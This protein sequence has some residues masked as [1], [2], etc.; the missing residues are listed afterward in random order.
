MKDGPF[1]LINVLDTKFDSIENSVIAVLQ[2][3]IKLNFQSISEMEEVDR[4]IEEWRQYLNRLPLGHWCNEII[5]CILTSDIDNTPYADH[6]KNL[7]LRAMCEKYLREANVDDKQN[8]LNQIENYIKNEHYGLKPE[9]NCLDIVSLPYGDINKDFLKQIYLSND[10]S[11]INIFFNQ[12]PKPR[13]SF[14]EKDQTPD[15]IKDR[16][17]LVDNYLS[18]FINSL[19]KIKFSRMES[20][21]IQA[22][23]LYR[24]KKRQEQ[25]LQ[26]IPKRHE[27]EFKAISPINYQ[28]MI[29]EAR[30]PYHPTKCSPEL[31]KRIVDASRNIKFFNKITHETRLEAIKSIFDDGLYGR[32]TLETMLMSFSPAALYPS[33]VANGDANVICFGADY[34]SI[35][36]RTNGNIKLILNFNKINFGRSRFDHCAFFKQMDFGFELQK[37]RIL[38]LGA[39]K[40]ILC[41]TGEIHD[42]AKPGIKYMHLANDYIFGVPSYQFISY[43]LEKIDQ[44]LILNFFKFLDSPDASGPNVQ[45]YVEELY[46]HIEHL[47]DHELSIF[48][49]SVGK[50]LSDTMEFNFFG[51]HKID[52]DSL[53]AIQ[54]R[55]GDFELNLRA[56]I[57]ELNQGE[58][59]LLERAQKEFAQIFTSYRFLDY[60][61]SKISNVSALHEL[62]KLR[63]EC[64]TPDWYPRNDLDLVL[65]LLNEKQEVR[66]EPMQVECILPMFLKY[67]EAES[68]EQGPSEK[69]KDNESVRQK[70]SR[71]HC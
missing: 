17:K 54:S 6:S 64:Q 20:L 16:E 8:I 56:L 55:H 67:A 1:S 33:D 57:D 44:T 10:L 18:T 49:E 66:P 7:I 19:N 60:L 35:D 22:Q 14:F 36:P 9:F 31:S 29:D 70:V 58:I 13:K 4:K 62:V 48:L 50:K 2:K 68:L 25:E 71:L 27:D 47:N 43:D 5:N 26:R 40:L 61:M 45:K 53:L 38:D 28:R 21:I 63:L 24:H 15:F 12:L 3:K 69:Q 59:G 37:D 65:K 46:Q 30:R 52:F 41:H 51:A 11:L 32:R 23:R 34:G 39:K 42:S